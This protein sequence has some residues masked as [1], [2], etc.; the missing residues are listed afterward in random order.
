[1]DLDSWVDRAQGA[2]DETST[3]V[4]DG[5][6]RGGFGSVLRGEGIFGTKGDQLVFVGPTKKRKRKQSIN[7]STDIEALILLGSVRASVSPQRLAQL[8][9][10]AATTAA[11]SSMM[12]VV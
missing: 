6:D 12:H 10:A 7:R 11:R 5:A 2:R 9:T 8:R 1:M 3:V 4:K